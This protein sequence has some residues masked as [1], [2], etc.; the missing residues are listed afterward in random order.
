M[1]SKDK[2]RKLSKHNQRVAD[3]I[4]MILDIAVHIRDCPDSGTKRCHVWLMFGNRG[5]GKEDYEKNRR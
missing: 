1:V 5:W 3:S 2:T 4:N